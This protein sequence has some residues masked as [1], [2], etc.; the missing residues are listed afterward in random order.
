[1][2]EYIVDDVVMKPIVTDLLERNWVDPSE[3]RE[4]QQIY[5][6][7]FIE[8]WFRLG[9][10]FVRFEQPLPFDIKLLE[11]QDTGFDKSKKRSWVDL[12]KGNITTWE[13]FEKYNWPKG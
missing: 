5:L 10:D 7:N 13:D 4:A 11:A 9:Y 2:V 3:N 1:M 12:Q 6:N 8:F